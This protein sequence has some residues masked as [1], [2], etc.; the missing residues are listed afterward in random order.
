MKPRN[1]PFTLIMVLF[2]IMFVIVPLFNRN[3]ISRPGAS[4]SA[5]G[6]LREYWQDHSQTPEE[7]VSALLKEKDILFVGE[8][9]KY[10]E[11]A[12]FINSLVT[13]LPGSGVD[14]IGVSFLNYPDQESIDAL[15]GGEEFDESLAEE[16][17]FRNLVMNGYGEYR[18]FLKEVW[19]VNR[20]LSD[21][22]RPLRLI[23]LNPGQDWTVL[24]KAGDSDNPE[25]IR[26]V[27]AAGVPDTFMA[28]V[29][30]KEILEPGHRG[31]IYA[32]IQNTLATIE[33]DSY[34]E[35]M[36]ENGFPEDTHRA[37][38]IIRQRGDVKSATLFIHAPWAVD[39]SQYGIDYPLGGVLDS[40]MEKYPP[41]ERRMGFLTADTPF[42]QLYSAPGSFGEKKSHSL[43]DLCDAYVLLGD[44]GDYTP[45]T[46]I[47]GFINGENFDRA[48]RNFPGPKE[49]MARTPAEMNE[50]IAGSAANL[51]KI[52]EKFKK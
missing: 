5:V 3:K 26:R 32:G 38:W 10:G 47:P 22:D 9:G 37:A 42:G 29:I 1:T 13:L 45:F 16:L 17:L 34:G 31:F 30:G 33:V 7:L 50:F 24:Q 11:T 23:G 40:F 52:L 43:S 20:D 51:K 28:D 48:V 4:R 25:V 27:Y 39:R 19:R 8:P 21:G 14:R 46:A 18:D 6:S 12:R 41:Q 2:I 36:A 15:I 49:S 35:K 44:I